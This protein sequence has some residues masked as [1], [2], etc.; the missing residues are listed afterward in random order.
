LLIIVGVV[1]AGAAAW[2][3]VAGR[4]RT[5][6][7]GVPLGA[8]P[9]RTQPGE[10]NLL[11]VTLDTTRADR[12]GAYGATDAGTPHLDRLAGE[13]ALFTRATTA[14][15]ITLPAHSSIFTGRFPPVHGVRDNGGFF[16]DPGQQT[17]A[18]TLEAS[19]FQTGGF[20]GA[21][22][23]DSKWGVNQGFK[24][25][26]DDFD[27]GK[28]KAIS[29]GAI[30][31]PG[32]EVV[33][34]A[35]KWLD[36]AS[37]SRFFAWVHL[38]DAHTPY[39]PPEPFSSRF[40][41][42]PYQGEISFADAQVGRLVSFLEE[43]NLLEKTVIVVVGDH[44]ESL[45]D[46]G[47]SGH[48]FFV[49]ESVMHVPMIVRTP[50]ALTR[51]RRVTDPVR[52]VDIMPT[53]LDLLGIRAKLPP[54]DGVSIVPL[55]AGASR[56]MNLEAYGEALYPLHHF[57][58]SDLRTLREGRYKVIA[59]PRP[60]LYDLE[61]DPAEQ[62]NLFADRRALG[63]RMLQRLRQ[64]ETD[65]AKAGSGTRQ[66]A[67]EV[68][69]D[70]KAR[71][72][73]LG[74]VGSFVK[75]AVDDTDRT[76]LADPKDKIDLFNR[77]SE[78]R[79][80]S[81]DEGSFDKVVGILQGILK[82]DPNV[83][84]A[85]FMLGNVHAAHGK[86]RQAIEYFKK[87]LA[88]KPDDEMAVVNMAN[89]YR[90]AGQDEEALVGY[91]RFL[92]LDPNNAQV[93]YEMA[94]ILIDRAEYDEAASAL[95]RALEL[96]PKMAA[97]Q[98]ALGVIAFRRGD[99]ALAQQ[100]I[101]KALAQ[102]PDVRLAHFN[103]A[104][105]AEERRDWNTAIAEYEKE[106]ADHPYSYKA[107]FNL[108]KLYEQLGDRQKQEQAFR[109]AI[110]A[111]TS[112]AEGYFYLAKLYLDQERNFDEAVSLARKGLEINTASPYAPLGHYVIADIYSR[113]GR[114]AEA[115]RE[116]AEG[117]RLEAQLRRKSVLN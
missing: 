47:E 23:L 66:E 1:G 67:V 83:I 93:R 5:S 104:L 30:Q 50:Y 11:L 76:S 42:R 15:P 75:S 17:L 110:D 72:A 88:L 7:T 40:P 55:L 109:R 41:G 54:L 77:I 116:A 95:R 29:L 97:A 111:N 27:L 44:G 9:P 2:W 74:Y 82:Q 102:K 18:E 71:L 25:Y 4:S 79:D 85:W 26:F 81:K 61:S 48:G 106:L 21:Y 100:E 91:R 115:A 98:N 113:T 13:G 112:F 108:G 32:N 52:T 10:L 68:D 24:K 56:R 73:A 89:A 3:F 101:R 37:R 94:Q 43:R 117:R 8:L 84:D 114:H 69:P 12:I 92:Q 99:V 78:A 86:P 58:W 14:A 34:E 16:L 103:L 96:E 38:Y 49:Y 87:A 19:G 28:Y 63:D 22:V 57:G 39:E 90:A 105:I 80:I 51:G 107:A 65:W 70:A 33:D 35:L 31:R 36:G 64:M 6:S 62:K 59:A 45:G 60:E 46:H 53:A 20:V